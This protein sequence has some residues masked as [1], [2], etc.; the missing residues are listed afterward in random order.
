MAALHPGDWT[1]AR[2]MN[3]GDDTPGNTADVYV[4]AQASRYQ[5]TCEPDLEPTNYA[6]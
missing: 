3:G 5:I 6:Q 1:T 4:S 2:H